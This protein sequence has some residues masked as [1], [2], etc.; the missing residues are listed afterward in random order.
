MFETMGM[1]YSG[2]IRTV[3]RFFS[4]LIFLGAVG[5]ANAQDPFDSEMTF[6]HV[7]AGNSA[8]ACYILAV[9]VIAKETPDEFLKYL[10][11]EHSDGNKVLFHSPGGSL[12]AGL[13]LGRIIRERE[14]ETDIGIWVPDREGFYGSVGEGGVCA[15]AC[16]YA[17]LGGTVRQIQEGGR[18]G[19]H[20]FSMA[21]PKTGTVP[22]GN[23][24]SALMQAQ[25]LSSVVVRYLLEMDIDARIFVLG[26]GAKPDD[27]YYPD[28]EQL[29]EF[30]L[31]SPIGFSEF[32]LEPYKSGLVAASKRKGKTRLYDLATQMTSYCRRGEPF[33]LITAELV[34][35]NHLPDTN[36]YFTRGGKT[37]QVPFSETR[38]RQIGDRAY[39]IALTEE[40]RAL[41][42][43]SDGFEF[44]LFLSMAAGG[45]VGGGL[46]LTDMDRQMIDASFRFCIS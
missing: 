21:A 36:L 14:L 8:M 39:E 30:A 28:A 16:A 12:L 17:F 4:G 15:S 13:E 6:E 27:M 38:I 11:T 7:C 35:Q 42:T 32:Y 23:L 26:S 19:F 45:N 20:Q 1:M 5:T 24:D 3:L 29:A 46:D 2:K 34:V 10:A 41:L 33:L 44:S 25:E 40:S 22:S 37:Q 31:I 43:T 18:L 9:G